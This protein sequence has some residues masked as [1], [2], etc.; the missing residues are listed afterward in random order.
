[1]W[2]LFLSWKNIPNY[3]RYFVSWNNTHL[4]TLG[5]FGPVRV[6]KIVEKIENMVPG[7]HQRS[8]KHRN[9][10]FTKPF[11]VILMASR[12]YTP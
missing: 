6:K 12:N 3:Y 10:R 4:V 11:F 5:L 1:M 2:G 8:F 9:K 7:T